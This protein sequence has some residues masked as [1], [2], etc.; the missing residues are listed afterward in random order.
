MNSGFGGAGGSAPLKAQPVIDLVN[1]L[2]ISASNCRFGTCSMESDHYICVADTGADGSTTVVMI[3]LENN[4]NVTRKP[5]KA[6]GALMNPVENVIAL[7]GKNE[8]TSGHFLQV[9]N[10]DTKAKLAGIGRSASLSSPFGA[11]FPAIVNNSASTAFYLALEPP[12]NRD[13]PIGGNIHY[14]GV[15]RLTKE[16]NEL[17]NE[18]VATN[19]PKKQRQTPCSG[20]HQFTEQVIF[21]RWLNVNNI[22]IVTE[23]SV[24][25]WDVT[26]GTSNSPEK[27]FDRANKLAE[28]STQII[29]YGVSEDKKWCLLTGLTTPDGGRTIDGSMQL[30][31]TELKATQALEGHAGAF[32][33]VQLADDG[34]PSIL[35]SFSERKSGTTI[36][37]L[38]IR[39]LKGPNDPAR[40][41]MIKL[42]VDVPI[43]PENPN[44][45]AVGCHVSDK[46]GMVFLVTKA[47]FVYMYDIQSG[48]LLYQYRVSQDPVFLSCNSKNGGIYLI[49]RKGQV[50]SV[51]ADAAN[52]V[53]FIM[54]QLTSVGNRM[55]VA[56]NLCMKFAIPGMDDQFK[57]KFN[58]FFMAGD[59]KNA[60]KIAGQCAS[61]ALRTPDTINKFKS[62]PQQPGQP[63]PSLLYFSVLLERHKLNALESE[64]VTRLVLAQNRKDF[65]E[66][67]LDGDKLECTDSL[68]DIIKPVDAQLALKVAMKGKMHQKVI[69]LLCEMG[70]MDKII[71]YVQKVGYQADYSF[72]LR[73]MVIGNPEAAANFAVKLLENPEKPLIDLN[74]V[75]DTFLS[76]NRIQEATKIM[77][78]ALKA[79]K[80][81]QGHLQTKLFEINLLNAPQVAEAIF[82]M[83]VFTH[84]DR[85]RI[86]QLAE[87]AGLSQRAMENYTDTTDVKRCLARATNLTPEFLISYFQKLSPDT[88][89]E[90][91]TDLIKTN[92][93]QNLQPVVQTCIKFHESV[94]TMKFVEMFQSVQ[95]YEGIFYFLGAIL[96]T[97]QDPEVYYSYI[98]AA[99]KLGH[100]QEVERVCRETNVYDPAKVKDFLKDQKLQDPRPLIYVC[101]L[102]GFVAELAEYLYKNN[103]MK[104]IEIYVTKVNPD[105]AP[106]VIGTLIDL[107]CTEDFIKGLL[108]NVQLSNPQALVTQVEQRHRLRLLQPWLEARIQ[109]GI[110]DPAIHN[111]IAKIYIETNKDPE[112]F[113]KTN[114]YYDAKEVG[115][116][117]E[118]RD[119]HLAFF[120]K[121]MFR[122]PGKCHASPEQQ[123]KRRDETNRNE[124]MKFYSRS[125]SMWMA[126]SHVAHVYEAYKKAWGTCD[127]EL[128][129]VTNNNGLFRLQAKYLVERQNN[130]LWDSVLKED[131]EHRRQ[132][133][134]QIVSTALPESNNP[135]EVSSTVKA[136]MS[137]D[138]PNE[139]I[140]LLEKIVLHNS[141]FQ[142]NGNL[143]NLLIVTA[144][145]ADKTRV[146]DYINRLDNFEGDK[147]AKIALGEPYQLYEEAFVIYKKCGMNAEAMDVLLTNI[148]SLERAQ[149]FASRIAEPKVWAR[150]GKSQ[151]EANMIS[152]AIESYLK[153]EDASDFLEVINAAKREENFTDLVTYLKMARTK[154][155]EPI[156]DT[157]LVYALAKTDQLGD[158][159]EFINGTNTAN[160]QSVGDRLFE[161]KHFKACKILFSHIT[162]NAKLASTYVHLGEYQMAVDAAKQGNN[163]KVWKEVCI[164]CVNAGEFSSAQIAGLNI[165]IHPDHL[166]ELI[167]VYENAGQTD[168]LIQLLDLGIGNERAHIGMYTELGILYAKYKPDRLHD[169]I[170]MNTKK[171]NIPKLIRACEKWSLW[172][173]AVYL[174]IHYDEND[175]AANTMMAHSDIAWTHE[176]FCVVMQK[177]SNFEIFYRAISFYLEEHAGEINS[178]L[179]AIQAKIDHAR[180]VALVKKTANPALI[181]PYLKQVQTENVQAVNECLNELYIESEDIENLRESIEKFDNIDQVV[182]AQ[183]LE[184]S[185]LLEMRRVASLL[186]TKNG[187]YKQ[188]IDLSKQDE[189]WKDCM[190]AARDSGQQE[191]A[192]S[193]LKFFVENG[194]GECFA[195]CLYTC[196]DLI[197]PDVAMELAWRNK[198]MDFAMPYMIQTMREYTVRLDKLE[199]KVSKKDEEDAKEKSAANDFGANNMMGGALG[200]NLALT[201]GPGMGGMQM[202]MGG[203]QMGGMPNPGMGMGSGF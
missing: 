78:E 156:I 148:E 97:S 180:V 135:E 143:Q 118:E 173:E 55:E 199:K 83:N 3:D 186:Y 57:Q 161:E 47:G 120:R 104:Y 32:G 162:N 130:E 10:L 51:T 197:R 73:N 144:L 103:L 48:T 163:P 198:L 98:E 141:E 128:V 165:I 24:Y 91:L 139:L 23:R 134:D 112:D 140:E 5:M 202:P 184:K 150:L 159:E 27:M 54:N 105:N 157:E 30:Y 49:T 190:T 170:K 34:S 6:E 109:Q 137:A 193:L 192:E 110:T 151:L 85:Q 100:V 94:G 35:L 145:K 93:R 64:E 69:T 1:Q 154:V 116:F 37:T 201:A 111:A 191:L 7:K 81:E 63:S 86:A 167:R 70:Q 41:G 185:D 21:W 203:M 132:V 66:K 77:L 115:A 13:E 15:Q 114:Q 136:F 146:M 160:V 122:N 17:R 187:R 178:L 149:E 101:D 200:G 19:A 107:D 79:N 46:F 40:P 174:Y 175:S 2:N 153:A 71:P 29:N 22:A 164:A 108:Q 194:D 60:A 75:V 4:N 176:E 82:Q 18:Q 14:G 62:A 80:P 158:M 113:L 133:I 126:I 89:L 177:V 96:S 42:Q 106:T 38:H 195:A 155:K 138:L 179:N 65:V 44:D 8:G 61:G 52:V 67:W 119:P 20:M 168:Q 183:K 102:H 147:I 9:F 131:N 196:Y 99:A 182:L 181:M 28:Q 68:C 33:Q 117:C 129:R 84:Y 43:S 88:I 26:P 125:Q 53:P 12:N 152:D 142:A 124:R 171:F 74:M 95:S 92:P 16:G 45:F 36:T 189:V 172:K 58:Q 11:L 56:A 59:F 72:L 39:E 169:F 31:N 123:E 76:Q 87:K 25:H 127:A 188:S 166:E 121:V 90:C 50:I